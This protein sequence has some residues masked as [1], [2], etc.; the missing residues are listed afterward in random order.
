MMSPSLEKALVVACDA[1]SKRGYPAKD[2]EQFD[3]PWDMRLWD[4]PNYQRAL[5]CIEAKATEEAL[6]RKPE[7]YRDVVLTLEDRFPGE[8]VRIGVSLYFSEDMADGMVDVNI[9]VYE[10]E[11]AGNPHQ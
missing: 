8:S 6:L 3:D 1:F 5:L 2:I 7:I 4:S 9:I 10:P 11:L